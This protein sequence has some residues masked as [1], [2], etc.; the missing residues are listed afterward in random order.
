[1]SSNLKRLFNI[2]TPFFAPR[3][4]RVVITTAVLGWAVFE[5]VTGSPGWAVL[6]GAAGAWCY[7]EFFVAFD[8][9]NY[10]DDDNG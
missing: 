7:Y 4:R 9:D 10:K 8:P 3:G 6:F 1:M 2:R 5:L